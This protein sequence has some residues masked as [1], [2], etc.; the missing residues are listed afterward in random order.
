MKRTVFNF[1]LTILNSEAAADHK[2][3]LTHDDE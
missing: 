3:S 1:I 2:K